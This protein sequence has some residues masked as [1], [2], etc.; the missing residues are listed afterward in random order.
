MTA[1]FA[2]RLIYKGE[3][4]SMC[5]NP[6][7]LWLCSGGADIRFGLASTACWRGYVGTWK[8][9]NSRLYLIDISANSEDGKELS[10]EDLFPGYG[11]RV[12]A[13][14]FSGEVRCPQGKLLNYVHGGYASTY[15]KD[16]FLTFSKGVLVSERIVVNGASSEAG[17]E[18]YGVAAFTT[19]PLGNKND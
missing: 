16:L 13:H 17:P 7:N 2:E 5:S 12:F 1:Q 8:I 10:V 9:I 14:W 6:L 3:E 19:Y 4:I 11:E 18:G 15:E